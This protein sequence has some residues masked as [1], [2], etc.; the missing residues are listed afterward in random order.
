MDIFLFHQGIEISLKTFDL[1]FIIVRC[2]EGTNECHLHIHFHGCGMVSEN[3]NY[4]NTVKLL[5]KKPTKM[6]DGDFNPVENY[7][8]L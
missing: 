7:Q 4:I 2:M 3:K 1:S 8:V 5:Q 6:I